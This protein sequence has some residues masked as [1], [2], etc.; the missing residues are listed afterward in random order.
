V[1]ENLQPQEKFVGLY[2]LE[3]TTGKALASMILDVLLRLGLSVNKLRGQAYDGAANMAGMR[4]G[5]Q[6]IIRE[7]NPLALFVHCGSH[8][9]NL[10]AQDA[11][12]SSV[13]VRD[14]LFI[15]NS[16]VWKSQNSCYEGAH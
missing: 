10:V 13:V 14:S 11:C 12:E 3:E 15:L 2:N 1:D 6:A 5:A 9:T 4:N 8:C 7:K 16:L